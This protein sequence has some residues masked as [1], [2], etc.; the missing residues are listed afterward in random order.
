MGASASRRGH[1]QRSLWRVGL[2]ARSQAGV[3][4][5]TGMLRWS[6]NG[7]LLVLWSS[8]HAIDLVLQ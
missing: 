3:Q 4:F 1:D 7:T 6:C 5:M 2:C 8:L